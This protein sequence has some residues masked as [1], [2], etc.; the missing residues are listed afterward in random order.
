MTPMCGPMV[1][2]SVV[3]G[4]LE[5]TA[6]FQSDRRTVLSPLLHPTA[7]MLLAATLT[8]TSTTF[9][10][11]FHFYPPTAIASLTEFRTACLCS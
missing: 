2:M 6:V 4:R 5:S 9:Y 7:L 1:K 3:A 8:S 10:F 11:Y